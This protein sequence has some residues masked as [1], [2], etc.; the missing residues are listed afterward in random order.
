MIIILEY[1]FALLHFLCVISHFLIPIFYA[2]KKTQT[3]IVLSLKNLKDS[4][5][6]YLSLFTM[7]VVK[8]FSGLENVNCTTLPYV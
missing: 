2:V 8:Y 1:V 7:K 5:G 6:C 3:V 4:G